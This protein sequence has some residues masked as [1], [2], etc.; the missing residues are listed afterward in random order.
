MGAGD[1]DEFGH[2]SLTEQLHPLGSHPLHQG[3]VYN[4]IFSELNCEQTV[5]EMKHPVRRL[6]CKGMGHG[7]NMRRLFAPFAPPPF[8]LSTCMS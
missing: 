5:G 4:Q 8:Q 3:Q 6:I 1:H 2:L 7:F